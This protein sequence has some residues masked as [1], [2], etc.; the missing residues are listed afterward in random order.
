VRQAF[1]A[2]IF[3]TQDMKSETIF[4]AFPTD[5]VE[6]IYPAYRRFFERFSAAISR[7][8]EIKTLDLPDIWVRDF[9]PVQHIK[10]GQMSQLF[11]NPHY[12]NYTPAFKQ[13]IRQA[14]HHYFPQVRSYPLAGKSLCATS[15]NI[16]LPLIYCRFYL[17]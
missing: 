1:V 9:L 13:K 3:Y 16:S 12:A 14:V 11:F 10:T 7:F 8:H 5:T 6:K 4:L 17:E 15:K 2:R